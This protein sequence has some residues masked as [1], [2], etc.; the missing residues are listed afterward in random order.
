MKHVCVYV[1][2][3]GDR[4][5][6]M[7]MG[8]VARMRVHRRGSRGSESVVFLSSSPP[9]PLFETRPHTEPGAL[10][11]DWWPANPRGLNSSVW[12]A[13]MCHVPRF[14]LT[15]RDQ[16]LGLHAC[17]TNTLLSQP[18]PQLSKTSEFYYGQAIL[19]DKL[20]FATLPTNCPQQ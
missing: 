20:I 16:N 8:W 11:L 6:C 13:G 5:V 4:Y 14:Y 9:F 17:E 2:V 7:L 10:C 15:A 3:W 12:P 1:S 19:T 18:S